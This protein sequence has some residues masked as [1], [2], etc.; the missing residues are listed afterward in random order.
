[1]PILFDVFHHELNN[2]GSSMVNILNTVMKTWQPHDG[3][4]MVDYSYHHTS[5]LKMRHIESID[6]SHFKRF[7]TT[8]QPYDFD[9]MLE[10][11]DKETS[12]LKAVQIA[13]KDM[14]FSHGQPTS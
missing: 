11:K 7:L 8:T 4:P 1:V 5:G 9:I 14:R 3:I 10:I 13:R 2:S 12:A 6:G